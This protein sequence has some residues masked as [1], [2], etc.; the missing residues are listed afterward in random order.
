MQ[1][2]GAVHSISPKPVLRH[3][4]SPF[5]EVLTKQTQEM[6][7]VSQHQVKACVNLLSSMAMYTR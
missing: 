2:E 1:P 6:R 5:E 4:M 3:W 7:P